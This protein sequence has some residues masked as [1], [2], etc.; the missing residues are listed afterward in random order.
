MV[1]PTLEKHSGE[2]IK[3]DLLSVFVYRFPEWAIL[4]TPTAR[5]ENKSF[6]FTG[7]KVGMNHSF[8]V[9][10][11][12][13]YGIEKAILL[14]NFYF[15]IKKNEANKKNIH[16]GRP[17]TY[18]SAEAFEKLFPYMK[19]RRIAQLLREMEKEDSLLLS[20]QFGQ[21]NRTKSY[22]LTDKALALFGDSIIQN[23]DNGKS[24]KSMFENQ[25]SVCC[26]NTDINAVINTGINNNCDKSQNED[27]EIKPQTDFQIIIESYFQNY[28]KLYEQK[29]VLTEK[30]IVNMKQAGKMIKDLLPVFGKDKILSALDKA[31][32]DNWIVGQ[33]YSLTTILSSNQL[34]K[35]INSKGVPARPN[36]NCVHEFDDKIML[37]E[38]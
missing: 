4:G 29:A 8:N 20:G 10:I 12:E 28:K 25:K 32:L 11:A 13:Q 24:K 33:G 6:L 15:W 2:Q 21:Y 19:A 38:M 17:Y 18:N 14:E 7:E 22:S 35:L 31:L 23:F 3:K 1:S 27:S 37:E 26:L 9:E 34:N 16:E 5:A 36:Y 30:P